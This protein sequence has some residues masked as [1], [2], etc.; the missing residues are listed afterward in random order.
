MPEG[1]AMADSTDQTNDTAVATAEKPKAKPTSATKPR[2]L[3]PYN[4]VLLN[5]DAHT[6]E[7]VI[8]M[9]GTLFGH[10]RPRGFKLAEQVD[11]TGRAIVLTTSK[12]HAELKRDQ[13]LAFG[14]DRRIESCA[15]SMS[16]IIEP[17]EGA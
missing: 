7:Y 4:V 10:P 17:A 8:E 9:L 2:Q 13:I 14:A 3:P 16:A 12:E 6:Y 11:H 15:G 1:A 5:D